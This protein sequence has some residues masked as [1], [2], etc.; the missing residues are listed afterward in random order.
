MPE[1]N[2]KSL[3]N[4]VADIAGDHYLRIDEDFGS[5]FV[6]LKVAE[7]D[8]R[9]AKHDIRSVEDIAIELLRN[10][11]DAGANVIFVATAKERSE[12]RHVVVVDDGEGIPRQLHEKIF[13][14]RVTSRLNHVED[15]FGVHGRGMA[16][17]AIREISD[18]A[19]I[20]FSAPRRGCSVK[21]EVALSRL[22]ER[23]DQSTF[24][25][26]K[27]RGGELV[28]VGPH[29]LPRVVLEFA[30]ANPDVEIYF[31]SHAEILSTMYWLSRPLVGNRSYGESLVN[32]DI[33]FWQCVGCISEGSQLSKFAK[34]R[35][36]LS[37]SERNASRVIR[38][39]VGSC[40]PVIKL[41]NG[42]SKKSAPP[43]VQLKGALPAAGRISQEDIDEFAIDIAR[44]FDVL[45]GKYFLK[46][47]SVEV[48]N[49]RNT[50]RIKVE[51]ADREPM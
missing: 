14:P 43:I 32:P 18:R 47:E 10:S 42:G 13:E 24:P 39:E 3:L 1:D 19:T 50:L 49:R 31:G 16:L 25:D 46:A 30:I 11:R 45:G 51:L 2:Q 33:K 17:F 23:K 8:K 12:T 37:V 9:Q 40:E 7:A 35:L 41:A 20:N 27:R 44:S 22:P 6:R 28:L 36:G 5:G 48:K 38:R 21:V 34:T 15:A 26:I 4:F 29:N